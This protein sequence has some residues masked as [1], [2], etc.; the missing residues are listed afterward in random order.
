MF[1]APAVT[2]AE[3]QTF[4]LVK[5][6]AAA[7]LAALIVATLYFGREVFVPIALA[8]LLSFVLAPL[9]RLLQDRRVP[10]AFSV[11]GVVLLAFAVIF[12]LGG[13]IATQ[14]NELAGD[15]PRYESNMRE[16][17]NRCAGPRLPARRWSAP[18]TFSRISA[19]S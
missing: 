5:G 6:V 16:K 4:Q 9:V 18:R 3:D 19:R 10:R 2:R 1:N 11:V 7:T 14:I 8:I 12:G 13:V 15:L 17:I